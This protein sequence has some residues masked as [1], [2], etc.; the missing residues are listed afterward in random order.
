MVSDFRTARRKSGGDSY[1]PE[2]RPYVTAACGEP[3]EWLQPERE[4]YVSPRYARRRRHRYSLLLALLLGL[5][6][7][8]SGFLLGRVAAMP[9]EPGNASAYPA[10][11]GTGAS[12]G[13]GG[14]AVTLLPTAESGAS[15]EPKG[16]EI[17]HLPSAET[18]VSA[19]P[20]GTEDA[21]L[22]STDVPAE[23]K[24]TG[25]TED[26][27]LILVN[28]W[29]PI[30]ADYTVT[31]KKLK[32]G[33]AVDER[34]YPDL[35][36]MLNDC[37]AADLRPMICSSYRTQEKQEQLFRNKVERL[38]A[39]GLSYED[40]QTEAGRSVAVPGT[41]EHQLGLALDIVGTEN[42]NLDKSQERTAVQQWLMAHCWEYGFILRYPEGKSELTGIIYE[43]WHYRYVGKEV[44]REIT[45]RGICLE[46]YLA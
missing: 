22:A 35:Q 37:R 30:P 9:L 13:E 27:N 38:M 28:P 32:N 39:K 6:L 33:H 20:K 12:A 36:K 24:E 46:E 11:A 45:E 16:A 34:C 7:F 19:E 3:D 18:D 23:L 15:A 41:S 40:A 44:A 29:N 4:Y 17:T 43:P 5:A 1:R 26:W 25:G 31:L 42:Q 2:R 14:T 10:P 8:G 21:G